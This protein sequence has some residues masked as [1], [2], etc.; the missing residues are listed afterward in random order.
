[1]MSR[2]TAVEISEKD[3]LQVLEKGLAVIEC[4]DGEGPLTVSEVAARAG[5]SRAAARRCLLTLSHLR[6]ASFDGKAFRL[7]PR[8]LRLGY[9]YLS[10]ASLPEIIQPFLQ[11]ICAEI[12]ES[13]SA[14]VLEGTDVIYI[15]R[16]SAKRI[17]SVDLHVGSR[18]PAYCTATGRVLLAAIPIAQAKAILET[19]ERL[20]R[21]PRTKTAVA[22]LMQEIQQARELGYSIVQGE[23]EP[24]LLTLAVPIFNG[25]GATVAAVNVG[26]HVHRSTPERLRHDILPKLLAFQSELRVLIKASA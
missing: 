13:T 11:R 7:A 14:T 9:A 26:Y 24:E 4:F 19:T 17:I 6:Y 20:Q 16:A 22:D 5:L 1:M 18:L 15:A 10:G 8:I 23:L 2:T 25:L 21:T 12:N 3:H